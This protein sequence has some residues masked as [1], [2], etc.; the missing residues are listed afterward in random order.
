MPGL[1]VVSAGISMITIAPIATPAAAAIVSGQAPPAH[2]DGPVPASTP[3][4][5]TPSAPPAAAETRH[6]GIASAAVSRSSCQRVAPRAVSMADSPSRWPASSRAE[7]SSAAAAS[8][9]SSTAQMA[10]SE[11]ATSRSLAVP[12]ST[13]GRLVVRV[14]VG[15]CWAFCSASRSPST[16]AAT[17]VSWLAG[18]LAVCGW[19]SQVP[20]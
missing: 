18:M 11:R 15:S 6:S 5:R 12:F 16:L 7:A 10:S 3:A 1:T 17:V 4:S 13:A 20:V 19:A 9:N 2:G 14:S 8:R